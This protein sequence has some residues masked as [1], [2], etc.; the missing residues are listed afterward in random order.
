MRLSI[1]NYYPRPTGVAATC[2]AFTKAGHPLAVSTH[3]MVHFF[4]LSFFLPDFVASAH[5]IPSGNPK[6]KPASPR[7][8]SLLRNSAAWC[9]P[10][11]GTPSW[12]WNGLRLVPGASIVAGAP[13]IRRPY[14]VRSACPWRSQFRLWSATAAAS[15]SRG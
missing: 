11:S 5:R 8:G 14:S 10:A 7:V 12:P 6:N 4:H 15:V 1:N 2:G 9:P 13:A 3:S